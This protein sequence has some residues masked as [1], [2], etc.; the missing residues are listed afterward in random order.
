MSDLIG[1]TKL[2]Y[3]IGDSEDPLAIDTLNR[4]LNLKIQPVIKGP[5]VGAE[6]HQ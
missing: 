1:D 2:D 3:Q 5:G 6:R 4:Q